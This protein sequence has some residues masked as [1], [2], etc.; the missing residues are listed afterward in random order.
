MR[1]Y[2]EWHHQYDDPASTLSWRLGVVQS[3]IDAA[4]DERAGP[5][6]VLS[7]CAGDGRDVIGVLSRRSDANRVTATLVELHPVIAETA[8]ESA[9][10]AG[11]TGVRVRQADA[12][13]TDAYVDAVP[14][15][16]VLLVGIFGNITD[17]DIHRTIRAAPQFCAP[18]ATLV[19][20]R[21]RDDSDRNAQIR[22]WF[23]AAGFTEIDY[24]TLDEGGRPAVGI[25]RY[26]G[27]PV[28]LVPDRPLF[29]FFR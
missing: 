7:A 24:R 8:A 5:V 14:A 6:R 4:L 13:N 27:E 20:S 21:G 9:E 25:V 11:L 26:V 18:G 10:A 29:T 17:A 2:E 19:W 15:D 22:G 3:A 16:L 1:D 23:A 12:G 28:E